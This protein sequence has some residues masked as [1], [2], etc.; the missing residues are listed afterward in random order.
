RK[1]RAPRQLDGYH[2][3]EAGKIELHRLG[4]ARQVGNAEYA[5]VI[6]LADVSEDFAVGRI[7]EA[8]RAAPESLELGADGDHAADPVEQRGR[9]ALL[10]F[11]VDRLEAVDRV[12]DRRQVELLRIGTGEAAV[13]VRRPLH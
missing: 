7:E 12:H 2:A 5:L 13:A 3:P 11:D 8:D 1:G 4:R 9:I 6:P 10:R